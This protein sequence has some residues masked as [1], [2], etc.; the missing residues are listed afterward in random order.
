[1]EKRAKRLLTAREAADY[2]GISVTTLSRMD[3]ERQLVPFR[4]PGGHRRYSLTMLDEYLEGS[5]RNPSALTSSAAQ[6]RSVGYGG[7]EA[8]RAPTP[9]G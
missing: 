6:S 2:L 8:E 1:M 7:S 5:R 9:F 3:K 4:T